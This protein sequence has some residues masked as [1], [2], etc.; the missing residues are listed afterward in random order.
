[1]KFG[2]FAVPLAVAASYDAEWAEFQSV[3]G[4]R[5][6]EVT[7][8]FKDNVDLV[9]AHNAGAST[10]E[11]SYVGPFADQ[12]KD[13][14]RE[15]LGYMPRNLYGDVPRIEVVLP[16]IGEAAPAV[17]W[18]TKGAV[19]AVKNQGHCGSC[20]AFSTTGALEGA[21]QVATGKLVSLSE[22]QLVDCS[23]ENHGCSGGLMDYG[24]K[25]LEGVNACA[26]ESYPYKGVAGTCASSSCSVAIPRGGVTSFVDVKG[27]AG[28]LTALQGRPVSVAIEADQSSFQLYKSGVLTGRCG[29][30]L[31]H[32]VLVV[33]YGKDG[34]VDYWKV[35]NSWGS[36][37]GE[38]GYVRIERGSNKCGIGN[39][40]SY[41]VVDGSV[42]PP[43]ESSMVV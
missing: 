14:Y 30:R 36:S 12:T 18:S 10:F 8:A 34:G 43:S 5:N 38:S 21:W 33:G 23:K 37:W 39:Q 13:E 6:G 28:L 11:L 40:P 3:Q 31:D 26:E 20:W 42:K 32:G 35:K 1:M 4:P 27:E 19:T 7:Q 22:Q 16:E 41:P 25:F 17:D 9:R 15:V 24:F 2:A 29:T